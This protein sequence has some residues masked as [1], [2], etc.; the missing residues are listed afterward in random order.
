M[1]IEPTRH[2]LTHLNGFEDRDNHQIAITSGNSIT[3]KTQA[4]KTI[5]RFV[6]P[7]YTNETKLRLHRTAANVG[8]ALAPRKVEN[9]LPNKLGTVPPDVQPK[10]GRNSKKSKLSKPPKPCKDFP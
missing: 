6:R 9:R 4:N 8:D 1:G 5:H 10:P 2:G 7:V 3:V